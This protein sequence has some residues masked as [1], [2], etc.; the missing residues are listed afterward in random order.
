LENHFVVV[1]ADGIPLSQTILDPG[2][3]NLYK[4]F[5]SG[6]MTFNGGVTDFEVLEFYRVILPFTD[7]LIIKFTVAPGAPMEEGG[8][9]FSSE[10][11]RDGNFIMLSHGI[12]IN[13]M[14][15]E[16]GVRYATKDFDDIT[17]TVNGGV[18]NGE[19][20]EIY[21]VL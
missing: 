1:F 8:T 18:F 15:D 16:A 9:T 14:T 10:L 5:T 20:I 6:T 3:R 7:G 11:L 13:Q 17:I 2:I 19:E 4:P 12:A 21:R